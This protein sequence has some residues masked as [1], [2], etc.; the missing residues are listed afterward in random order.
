MAIPPS[1]Q[2][3]PPIDVEVPSKSSMLVAFVYVSVSPTLA[4]I[5]VAVP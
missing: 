1:E 5:P 3:V 2:I 4:P